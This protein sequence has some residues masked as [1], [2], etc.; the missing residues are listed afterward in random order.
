MQPIT[1]YHNNRCGKSRGA[2][3]LLRERGI[4]PIIRYYLEEAP[5]Q[6][7]LRGL[8][9]KLKIKVEDLVRKNESLYK[10]HYKGKNFS[11]EEWLK[12]L[13]ENPVL[14]ERPVVI[15]GNKAVVARPPEK[16]LELL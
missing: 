3:A 12:I 5:T 4:E 6:E 14:I 9:N 2:L 16:V 8:L 13:S 15:K 1:I 10:A 11:E 7:E